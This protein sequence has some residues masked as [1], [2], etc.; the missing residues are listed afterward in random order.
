M[1]K[2]L[3]I[4]LG[5]IAIFIAM[6]YSKTN[7]SNWSDLEIGLLAIN[8]L[9]GI[10]AWACLVNSFDRFLHKKYSNLKATFLSVPFLLFTLIVGIAFIL[11]YISKFSASNQK[12]VTAVKEQHYNLINSGLKIGSSGE[13]I[14]ILQLVL[15]QDK[16]IYPSGLISG[17]YGNL[18]QVAVSNFQRKYSIKESGTMDNQTTDKF[19]EVYGVQTRSHYLNLYPTSVPQQTYIKPQ[20]NSESILN[21]DPIVKCNLN[22][23]C[24]G[25]YRLLSQSQCSNSTCCQIGNSWI[26]YENKS[27]CTQ[28]QNNYYNQSVKYTIPTYAPLPTLKPWPTY[29][30]LP[31]Y[32]PIPT[33][34]PYVY[35]AP[36][37]SPDQCKS[38]VVSYYAGFLQ[39]CNQYGGTSA[40]DACIQIYS[41]ERNDALAQ[42]GN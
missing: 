17:Y 33:I 23:N 31:T 32:A 39:S 14:K 27:K 28:D 42:C 11:F 1:L 2:S 3:L 37:K 34:A 21:A 41:N 22:S 10:V 12:S 19:N 4:W 20:V 29:A 35:V 9:V 24:G 26:F 15:A 7:N 16:N 13:D 25:G 18:T 8:I 40:Y 30:P 6:L 36:T 5:T 38:E